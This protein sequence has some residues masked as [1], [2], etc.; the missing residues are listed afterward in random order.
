MKLL[1]LANNRIPSEKANSLQIMQSCAA[2]ARQGAEVSLVVPHRLQPKVM[3]GVGDPFAY[4]GIE[5]RFSIERL[6]CI[7]FLET[8]PSRLQP[9]AFALQAA[10]FAAMAGIHLLSKRGRLCYTRDPLSAVL[11]SAAPSSVRMSSVYEAHTFPRQGPKRSLHLRATGRLGGVVCITHGLAGEYAAGGIDPKRIMVAADAV[12]L[13]RFSNLP[14]RSEARRETG[15]P[16]AARV[17]CYAGHLYGWKGVRTLALASRHLPEGYLI[18][19]VGGTEEDLTGFRRFLQEERLDRV[20]A[21]GHV[22]PDRVPAYLAAADVLALP[23]SARSETS[24]RFTSPMKLFEYMAAGRP[25][26][27]SRLPSLQ[28]VLRDG[29]NAVLVE[30]DDP[31]ALA[32][33]LVAVAEDEE[34]AG[35]LARTAQAEV[36][37]RTWDAR[38]GE[39]LFFL[40]RLSQ[41]DGTMHH[42]DTEGTEDTQ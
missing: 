23:N 25:I 29:E 4:Y 30:P 9:A 38:A 37:G 12:D 15:L 36:Q 16:Q 13:A 8:A 21:T 18:C 26:V 7:D 39:I 5:K 28:E 32:K 11:L 40:D 34:M 22:T 19:I 10:S 1:Y 35:R 41:H 42:R 33:G 24:A 14:S 20:L 31:I 2:F 3:R 27:A 6:P 17:I